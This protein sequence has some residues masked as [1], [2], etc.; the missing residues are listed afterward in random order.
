MT[1]PITLY[2]E[3]LSVLKWLGE[4]NMFPN[5]KFEELSLFQFRRYNFY[6]AEICKNSGE[7][8][9]NTVKLWSL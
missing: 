9:K 1:Y 6:F 4:I 8:L 7:S 3:Q 5:I 2:L